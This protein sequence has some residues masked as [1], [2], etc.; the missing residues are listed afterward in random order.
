MNYEH[1][2]HE[3]RQWAEQAHRDHW[4]TAQALATLTELE[5]RSPASLF[6]GQ[7]DRPLV[8]AFFGGTGVGK[9][10]LLNRLA[11]QAVAR[12]GV[13]RPTS[14]EISLYLHDSVPRL[15]LP[16]ACPTHQV[17]QAKHHNDNRQHILWVDMPDIDSVE[18]ANRDLVLAWLPHVDVV[19]YVVSPERY[20]DDR[21]WRLLKQ[22]G[23]QHA[24]L[25]VINQWDR[26]Y[27]VQYQDFQQLLTRT[28]FS[29]PVILRTDCRDRDEQRKT[30]DFERLQRLLDELTERHIL[31]QLESRA[32]SLRLEG[33]NRCLHELMQRLGDTDGYGGLIPFFSPCWTQARTGIVQGLEW[34]MRQVAREF[35]GREASPLKRRLKL[36]PAATTAD[37]VSVKP[38]LWDDWAN[39]QFREVM[40]QLLVEAGQRGLATRPLRRALDEITCQVERRVLGEAQHGL[41]QALIKPGHALQRGLM[42]FTGFLSLL[43]PLTAIGWV[44]TQVVQGYYQGTQR[45]A[46]WLGTDFAIHSVIL[47]G[48]AWLL[49]FFLHRIL[50]PSAERSA[51]GGLRGG[52]K[53]AL[54]QLEGEVLD[55]LEGLERERREVLKAGEALLGKSTQENAP[56]NRVDT[57]LVDRV[58]S[59][60][61][62][63]TDYI[64]D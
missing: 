45:E 12:T 2:L 50:T 22:H 44:S 42:A 9:S 16:P 19:I 25:F 48:L 30:D 51:L 62:T 23:N 64:G 11:G 34:P 49:P 63:Q 55:R 39:N 24:W 10:T 41:R 33:L 27:E 3:A 43:L 18:E 54:G 8:A 40:E 29:D 1:L 60:I 28:G 57:A 35:V 38:V 59:N 46:A 20:R 53:R 13:E 52:V 36:L 21:G 58:L 14:R 61:K 5:Q 56:A 47:I 31:T 37:T 6:A 15:N 7:V 4:L 17:R 26:G 32:D